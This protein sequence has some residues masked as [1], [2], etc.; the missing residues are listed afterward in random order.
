MVRA[1]AM[2]AL[3]AVL[4]RREQRRSLC[5]PARCIALARLTRYTQ[6]ECQAVPMQPPQT[7]TAVALERVAALRSRAKRLA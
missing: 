1:T 6:L 3:C 5:A 4:G 2:C 7:L